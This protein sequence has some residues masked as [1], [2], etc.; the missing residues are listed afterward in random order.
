MG[1]NTT[2]WA[3][4]PAG[5][6]PEVHE[7]VSLIS[8]DRAAERFL[9]HVFYVEGFVAEHVGERVD[10]DTWMFTAATVQ[11]GPAGMRSRETLVHRGDELLSRFELAMA[12]KDFAVYTRETLRRVGPSR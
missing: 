4:T 8:Y 11:N 6:E 3:R 5:S 12:G 1:T 9:M 7:D 2:R 10:D